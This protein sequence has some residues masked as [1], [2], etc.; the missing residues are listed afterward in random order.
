[1]GAA[2]GRRRFQVATLPVGRRAPRAMREK[3]PK[4]IDV[5]HHGMRGPCRCGDAP[6]AAFAR[7]PGD[8]N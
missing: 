4:A 6:L 3:R 7:R 8:L 1:M 5:E 2:E